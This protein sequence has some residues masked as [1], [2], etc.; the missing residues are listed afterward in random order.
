MTKIERE[1]ECVEFMIRLYCRRCEG[2]E[3]LCPECCELIRYARQRL[4]KCVHAEKKP[5]C[6]RCAVHCYKPAMREKI[7]QVMRYSG[8]RMLLRRPV[9]AIRHLLNV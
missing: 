7:R 4:S 6:K 1:K 9:L 5:S 3:V 8:P 2:N